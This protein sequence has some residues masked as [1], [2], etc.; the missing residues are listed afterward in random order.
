MG[1]I[2]LLAGSEERGSWTM[3]GYQKVCVPYFK[4]VFQCTKAAQIINKID[5]ITKMLQMSAKGTL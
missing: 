3:L 4:R 5:V 1:E 2:V